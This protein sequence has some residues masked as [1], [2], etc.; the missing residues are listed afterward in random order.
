MGVSLAIS[1]AE[2]D[3]SLSAQ[4]FSR[5]DGGGGRGSTPIPNLWTAWKIWNGLE[6]LS[7][8][9]CLTVNVAAISFEWLD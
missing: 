1:R 6:Q 3:S 7:P 5:T 2:G 8:M 9:N 4:L